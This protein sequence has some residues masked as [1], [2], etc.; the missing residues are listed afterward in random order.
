MVI[1]YVEKMTKTCSQM[2]RHVF[3]TII[4]VTSDK[5]YGSVNLSNYKCCKVMETS[6]SCLELSGIIKHMVIYLPTLTHYAWV[7]RL[8]T[9]DIDLMH[10]EQFLTPDSQIRTS[11]SKNTSFHFR[12]VMHHFFALYN[13]R[14]SFQVCTIRSNR[15]CS[16]IVGNLR[17]WLGLF[18]KSR[19]WR[20]KNRPF[21]SEKVGRYMVNLLSDSSF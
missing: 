9:K 20:D 8:G 17:K 19:S 11:C 3:Y 7:S 6:A 21:D 18:R 1:H 10:Q 13:N 5:D 15:K 12:F 14:K 2:F 4:V 16:K